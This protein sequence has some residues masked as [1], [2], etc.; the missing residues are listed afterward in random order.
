[1]LALNATMMAA[2]PVHGSHYFVDVIAGVAITVVAIAVAKAFVRR[3][4]A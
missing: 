2:T 4:A 3:I 1:M